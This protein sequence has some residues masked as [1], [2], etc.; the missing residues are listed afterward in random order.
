[1]E[2]G[3]DVTRKLVGGFR[4]R[5][6]RD[7]LTKFRDRVTELRDRLTELR[8]GFGGHFWIFSLGGKGVWF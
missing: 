4:D 5:V 3:A 8:D 6:T 2:G 7:R 1:M